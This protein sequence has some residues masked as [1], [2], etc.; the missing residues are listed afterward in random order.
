[1]FKL[2][3]VGLKYLFLFMLVGFA[4]S[5]LRIEVVLPHIGP[6][7]KSIVRTSA[8]ISLFIGGL[9]NFIIILFVFYITT[10]I[11]PAAYKSKVVPFFTY[12]IKHFAIVM[13]LVE[14]AK[15]AL[16]FLFLKKE[17][18]DVEVRDLEQLLKQTTWYKLQA[19]FNWLAIAAGAYVFA[20]T[21]RHKSGMEKNIRGL[22]LLALPPAVLL[23]VA[24]ILQF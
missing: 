22:L 14:V 15:I 6:D 8:Y 18:Y 4:V 13:M 24:T 20:D 9:F 11:Q 21:V 17:L 2:S 12:G 19:V 7:Y 10:L 5:A 3:S 1:M 23:A 16:V